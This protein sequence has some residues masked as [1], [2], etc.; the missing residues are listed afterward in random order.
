MRH[1]N[2]NLRSGAGRT[3]DLTAAPN[4][5]LN[6]VHPRADRHV[7]ECHGVAGLDV[8]LKEGVGGGWKRGEGAASVGRAQT[9]GKYWMRQMRKRKEQ[10]LREGGTGE[11]YC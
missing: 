11:S 2:T 6:V 8:E 7:R 9:K 10:W 3:A 5:D 1:V 4:R